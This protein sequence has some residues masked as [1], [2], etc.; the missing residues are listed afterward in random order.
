MEEQ[1]ESSKSV[2]NNAR[3]ASNETQL[4]EKLTFSLRV[5]NVK[6]TIVKGS[7]CMYEVQFSETVHFSIILFCGLVDFI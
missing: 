4:P 6:Y 7:F 3:Q 5:F 2:R 1:P